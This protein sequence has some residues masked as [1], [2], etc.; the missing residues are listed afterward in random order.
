M[1]IMRNNMLLRFPVA[2]ALISLAFNTASANSRQVGIA[3][4]AAT[5][6]KESILLPSIAIRRLASR[7]R[8]WE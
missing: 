3:P 5:T 4:I 7:P 2:L 8:N 6:L 1:T